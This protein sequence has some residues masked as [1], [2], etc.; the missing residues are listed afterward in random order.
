M[1]LRAKGCILAFDGMYFDLVVDPKRYR[2]GA[3]PRLARALWWLLLPKPDLVFLLDSNLTCSGHWKQ[4]VPLSELDRQR[5]AN[6]AFV[7]QLPA[8]HVLSGSLPLSVLVDEIQRVIRAWM[9]DRS[10]ASLG[11]VQGPTTRSNCKR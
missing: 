7:R 11:G 8:G 3:G 1:H 9:L 6:R 10:V 2:H 5:H 4:E